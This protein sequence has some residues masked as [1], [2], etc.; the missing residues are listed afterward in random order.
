[1]AKR[2]LNNI[3]LGVFVLAGLLFLILLLYMMGK[4]QHLFGSNYHLRVRFENVQGLKP[5]HNVR[6]SGIE[7][8]TV[9]SVTFLNDTLIEVD[10]LIENRMKKIIRQNAI[11]AIGT[12]GFVGNKVVNIFPGKTS[13]ELAKENDLLTS[14]K[15]IDTDEMLRTLYRT[16]EDVSAVAAN[17]RSTVQ[18]LNNSDALWT[19][20][21]DKSLPANIRTSAINIKTATDRAATMISDLENIVANVK[22]GKGSLGAVLTDSSFAIN[23]NQAIQKINAVAVHADSLAGEITEFVASVKS[24]VNDGKGVVN[25][26]LKDSSITS[27]MNNSLDHI[28]K[29]TEAFNQDMEALKHNFLFRGYFKK[30]EKEKQ[31]EVKKSAAINK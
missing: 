1:M 9:K 11:V 25:A 19:L 28:E 31:K 6:Y 13:A 15:P 24:H 26:L 7:V 14:K 23:L 5:G 22:N 10:M 2:A 8:G 16:N 12:E 27:R 17:L 29:G 20:L 3:R 18:N 21:N 30:L 4:N